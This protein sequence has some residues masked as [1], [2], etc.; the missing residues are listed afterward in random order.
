M[1]YIDMIAEMILQHIPKTSKTWATSNALSIQ[2]AAM[3]K[4]ML[5]DDYGYVKANDY[6]CVIGASGSCKSVVTIISLIPIL[7]R[8]NKD[9]FL[10]ES[11]SSEGLQSYMVKEKKEVGVI[12]QD[13]ISRF[14]KE[15]HGKGYR[16]GDAE[17]LCKLW[18][19]RTMRSATISRG[20]EELTSPY[21]CMVASS[22]HSFIEG[23]SP[24]FF[25]GGLGPR[26]LW[27]YIDTIDVTR[28]TDSFFKV[29]DDDIFPWHEEVY[30]HMKAVYN[31]TTGGYMC[32]SSGAS[33]LWFDFDEKCRK[34]Y[35]QRIENDRTGWEFSSINRHPLHVL[36]ASMAYCMGDEN[37][38]NN[39]MLLKTPRIT[40][41]H[42]QKAID[43]VKLS[44]I[45]YRK[46]VDFK[47]RTSPVKARRT[48]Y[49]EMAKQ[50]FA[51]ID[52]SAFPMFLEQL[53]ARLNCEKTYELQEVMKELD[54][55]NYIKKFSRSEATPE[56]LKKMEWTTEPALRGKKGVRT[57]AFEK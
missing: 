36:K 13:E 4:Y 12:D 1:N 2:Q 21:V 24:H 18:D 46:I 57:T 26:I 50:K 29:A 55:L 48:D 35:A 3:H 34:E 6:Y 15:T 49:R 20:C 19:G 17:F 27:S 42:M 41:E 11:G 45:D 23:I 8:I 31:S 53:Y 44:D 28:K 40:E 47:L 39:P 33:E 56:E 43:F 54:S 7:K 14:Y 32:M 52:Q 16:A 51:C 25:S 10:P 9:I 22:T 30:K 5:K 38:V 37:T